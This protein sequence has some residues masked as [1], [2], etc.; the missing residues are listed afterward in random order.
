MTLLVLPDLS[1]AFDTVDH[2]VLLKRLE[3]RFGITGTVLCWF[4]TYLAGRS[5]R[6]CFE[7][8]YSKRFDLSHGVPQG[9]YLGPLLFTIYTSKFFDAC[10]EGGP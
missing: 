7:G 10:P 2:L 6:I 5:Q 1:D 4:A 9:S 8:R 3:S